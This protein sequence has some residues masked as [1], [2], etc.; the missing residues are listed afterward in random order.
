MKRIIFIIFFCYPLISTSQ[1][2]TI[3][4]K[5]IKEFGEEL[6]EKGFSKSSKIASKEISK[7]ISKRTII[8]LAEY[9]SK[10]MIASKLDREAIE[11]FLKRLDFNTSQTKSLYSKI[12]KEK[13]QTVY[14]WIN[15]NISKE[16]KRNL[17]MDVQDIDFYNFLKGSVSNRKAYSKAVFMGR[18]YRKSKDVIRQISN[19]ITPIR[20]STINSSFEGKVLEGVKFVR[21]T[22]QLPNKLKIS[23]VFPVFK[24]LSKIKLPEYLLSKPDIMQMNYAFMKFRKQLLINPKLQKKFP[25]DILQGMINRKITSTKTAQYYVKGFTWHHSEK[26]GVLELVKTKIHN[27]VKHTGGSA[28]WG[29]GKVYKVSN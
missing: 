1:I 18:K 2:A 3:S 6:V 13:L 10:K 21:K 8:D 7:K 17:L 20:I 24:S 12:G 11:K 22:I 27:K 5:I 9:R 16:A 4:K 23:G 26:T 29:G 19:N 14:T 15:P 28:I 25:P